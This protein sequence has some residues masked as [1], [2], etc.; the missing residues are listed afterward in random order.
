MMHRMP[1]DA[2]H[3]NTIKL[4]SLRCP[5]F[6]PDVLDVRA[7]GRANASVMFS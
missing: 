3:K 7:V 1:D 5:V 2:G 6:P 4:M